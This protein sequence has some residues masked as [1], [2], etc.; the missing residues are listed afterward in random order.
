M[1]MHREINGLNN[2]KCIHFLGDKE[3]NLKLKEN[4]SVDSQI[5]IRSKANIKSFFTLKNKATGKLLTAATSSQVTIAGTNDT[6]YRVS[7]SWI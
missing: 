4:T 3:A 2:Q 6:N 1:S 7:R 5:W